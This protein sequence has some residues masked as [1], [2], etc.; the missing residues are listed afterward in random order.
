[1]PLPATTADAALVP[2]EH[3]YGW[4]ARIGLIYPFAGWIME[5]EFYHLGPPGVITLTTRVTLT[6]ATLEGLADMA[7]SPEVERATAG[8]A[9]APVQVICF[10]GTSASFLHGPP[11]DASLRGRMA[12]VSAGIP[13]TTTS[14]ASVQALRALGAERIVFAGPYL[15][16]VTEQ[17][18][19]FFEA[20][21]FKVLNAV[22]MGLDHDRT[23]GR[24]TLEEVYRLARR[25]DHPD[26]DAVFISCTGLRTIGVLAALE[27][28]LGKPVV[29]AN[30]ASFW[31]C[32]RVAGIPDRIAGY[33]RLL[34]LA[35]PATTDRGD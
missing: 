5:P 33:G 2:A 3:I 9:T 8:L 14:H 26:A 22:G 23:I 32:L 13:V 15:A 20:S 18:R 31:H 30:Q 34:D 21:G 16:D 6:A 28:D 35:A 10:G 24:V 12:R 25:A 4:R 7:Q 17:G 1:V 29:S 27:R 19:Q 11:W